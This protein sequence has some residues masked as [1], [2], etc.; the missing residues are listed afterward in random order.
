MKEIRRPSFLSVMAVI[1]VLEFIFSIHILSKF[2]AFQSKFSYYYYL[3]NRTER[4]VVELAFG[5]LL[6]N[7]ILFY[8]VW[9]PGK[10]K[11]RIIIGFCVLSILAGAIDKD[12]KTILFAGVGLIYFST[13]EEVKRWYFQ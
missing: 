12:I 6:V 2:V 5:F 10:W 11:Y 4:E 9:R 8:C 13:N 3:M 7:P 1:F